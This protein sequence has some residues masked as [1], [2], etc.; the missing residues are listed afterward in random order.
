MSRYPKSKLTISVT[1]LVI[2]R[3]RAHFSAL[4]ALLKFPEMIHIGFWSKNIVMIL[5][6]H[7]ECVL[8]QEIHGTFVTLIGILQLMWIQNMTLKKYRGKTYLKRKNNQIE[9]VITFK[10]LRYRKDFLHISHLCSD[11]GGM[12]KSVFPE[13]LSLRTW[14]EKEVISNIYVH[15]E[16]LRI[17]KYLLFWWIINIFKMVYPHTSNLFK[18]PDN[19]RCSS[20]R[21]VWTILVA[22][23]MVFVAFFHGGKIAQFLIELFDQ[24]NPLFEGIMLQIINHIF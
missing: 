20:F 1:Y 14:K 24:E 8:L 23:V 11:L 18:K 15:V 10:L 4:F 6:V 2:S 22:A 5:H 19:L 17:W 16:Q 13:F 21:K 12:F 7:K 3:V 9:L